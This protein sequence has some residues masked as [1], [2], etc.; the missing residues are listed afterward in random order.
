MLCISC[1]SLSSF[2]RFSGVGAR[3]G[4][5]VGVGGGEWTEW[6]ACRDAVY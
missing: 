3:V 4:V 1:I 2:L 5:G 6:T